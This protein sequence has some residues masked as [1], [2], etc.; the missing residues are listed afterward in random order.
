MVEITNPDLNKTL[1][2]FEQ[3]VDSLDRYRETIVA[4]GERYKAEGRDPKGYEFVINLAL[5]RIDR[6]KNTLD[7]ETYDL[8]RDVLDSSG[9]LASVDEGSWI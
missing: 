9:I 6:L 5:R 3:M 1:D 4:L 2:S 8:F 7:G